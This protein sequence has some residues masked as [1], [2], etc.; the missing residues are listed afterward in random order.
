MC[1]CVH[2]CVCVGP[3]VSSQEQR[4]LLVP[5]ISRLSSAYQPVVNRSLCSPIGLNRISL[6]RA[7]G[8]TFKRFVCVS[9][10]SGGT[11]GRSSL[12]RNVLSAARSAR[13][14]P[15]DLT[16]LWYVRVLGSTG[17]MHACAYVPGHALHG[18]E[19]YIP[20]HA[21]HE[22]EL[23]RQKGVGTLVSSQERRALAVPLINRGSSSPIGLNGI[24][25]VRACK[26][27]PFKK[28][29]H[30][31][32]AGQTVGWLL[33]HPTRRRPVLPGPAAPRRSAVRCADPNRPWYVRVLD[34]TGRQKGAGPL[35]SSQDHRAATFPRINRWST[36]VFVSPSVYIGFACSFF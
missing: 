30:D 10:A 27:R 11:K 13:R 29:V 20:G 17:N 2:V 4:A 7:S 3:L 32:L 5:V 23:H 34:S 1:V 6:V 33:G 9:D 22:K 35:V 8:D 19:L 14:R 24:L 36:A 12:G 16:R 26:I 31:T 21:L 18:K 15:A 25:F 28:V